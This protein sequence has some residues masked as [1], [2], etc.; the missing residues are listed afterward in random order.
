MSGF[1]KGILSSK[2]TNSSKRLVTL[3]ITALFIVAQCVV[4]YAYMYVLLYIPKGKA[5][6]SIMQTLLDILKMDFQIILYG[7]G[8]VTIEQA[9]NVATE[10]FKTKASILKAAVEKED[11][12]EDTPAKKNTKRQ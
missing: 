5:D 8:F 4:I 9:G 1:W 6:P 10:Y 11:D 7:L 2:D 12:E 3:L